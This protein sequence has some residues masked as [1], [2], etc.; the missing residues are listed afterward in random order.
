[1]LAPCC[2]LKRSID[3]ART[4]RIRA[5]FGA[6]KLVNGCG[7]CVVKQGIVRYRRENVLAYH[8]FALC[9]VVERLRVLGERKFNRRCP[10]IKKLPTDLKPVRQNLMNLLFKLSFSQLRRPTSDVTIFQLSRL[11]HHAAVPRNG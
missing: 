7:R 11:L 4:M 1:M 10:S 3:V 6:L 2:I 8:D 5:F 9:D